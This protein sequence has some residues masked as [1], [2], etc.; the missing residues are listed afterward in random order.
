M[1][2]LSVE[3][4]LNA[5]LTREID[6]SKLLNLQYPFIFYILNVRDILASIVYF[7]IRTW[8]SGQQ[9]GPRHMYRAWTLR[10]V[11]GQAEGQWVVDACAM[12]PIPSAVLWPC[13]AGSLLLHSKAVSVCTIF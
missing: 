4:I 5:P 2:G 8:T 10:Q 12:R 7:H 3:T 6:V 1:A 13:T 9:F 11:L